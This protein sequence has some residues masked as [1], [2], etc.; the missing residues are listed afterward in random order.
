[1]WAADVA[2][3]V[4]LGLT[5]VRV[6]EFAWARL[7]P[8]PGVF[9]WGWLDRAVD[10]L[11]GAGLKV[12]MGTPSATPPRW[13]LARFPDMLA[14]DA[15]GRERGFGS[16]RHYCFSHRGYRDA[17]AEM[18]GR[19]AARYADRVSAWQTDNE[20]GC[21]DTVRSYSAAA[22]GAFREWLRARYGTAQALN[23]AWGNVFW[24]MDH[25]A[26]D[27][28]GLPNLTVTEPNPAHALA[29][30]RFASDEVA[31]WNAAQV[32]AIRVHSGAPISHNYMGLVTEFDHWT[33][34]RQM[35]I[36]TW[37]SYPLGFL[38]DRVPGGDREAYLRQGDSD[39]QAFHHD[40]YRGV[41]R[42]RWWV[43][44]QQPGPVNWA[45]WN[46]APAP[47][48]VRLW[49]WEAFAHGAEVVSWFRWRQF[50]QAQESQHAGLRRPDD[51]PGHGWDEAVQVAAELREAPEVEVG[52]APVA[53]VFDYASEWAWEVQPQGAGFGHFAL[54][55]DLYRALRGLGLSMDIVAPDVGSLDGYALVL[56]PGVLEVGEA[57]GAA[58][59]AAE[60]IVLT[61]PRTG[62]K[63]GEM[64]VPVPLGPDVP[65]LG[66]TS[67]M[68]ETFPP[69][70]PR[71]LE[72][73]GAATLWLE[74][75]EGEAEV[76]ERVVGGPPALVRS[77][78]RAHLATWPD[79]VAARRML[80][81]LAREAGL[82]VR[83]MPE[84]L[85][86]R[87]AGGTRF[88]FN[89]GS[90]AQVFEG[91]EVPAAGVLRLA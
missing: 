50:P 43:M 40:L 29:Y 68:E 12:V 60:G 5:W 76:V 90:A 91:Q 22:K 64:A 53:L 55:F 79:A 18:A 59:A 34:G 17:A 26:W 45:P 32:A 16:R 54:C 7:E 85:R 81:A 56:V 11:V 74:H 83:E 82:E 31:A 13:M 67:V 48:M 66:V 87:Q 23:D 77:G 19:M 44:E 9:D 42:G 57:L 62:S 38:L 27:E 8:E 70:A 84:G 86:L 33:L 75:L 20:Y 69:D 61:G 71:A 37:D 39:F 88:V 58:L 41:G 15:Q 36:A 3:M 2:R 73:G 30:R 1:M 35:E 21:H 49:T 80:G 4:E 24:S 46:P 10:L 89:Y 51:G 47:G 63:T 52:Q 14:V 78:R 65:G 72:G 28:I 6:G 25:R